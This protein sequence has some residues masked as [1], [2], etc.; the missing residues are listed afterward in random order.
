MLLSF[1]ESLIPFFEVHGREH[2]Q[3]KLLFGSSMINLPPPRKISKSMDGVLMTRREIE[4]ERERENQRK[5]DS[6]KKQS[7]IVEKKKEFM[8]TK[9]KQIYKAKDPPHARTYLN[10]KNKP[11]VTRPLVNG[12]LWLDKHGSPHSDTWVHKLF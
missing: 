5:T 4:R 1:S 6:T 11:T 3:S 9:K 8:D 7:E 10:K 12:G 2:T